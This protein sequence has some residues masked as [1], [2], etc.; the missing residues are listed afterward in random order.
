MALTIESGV[1]FS[2]NAGNSN[3]SITNSFKVS[4]NSNLASQSASNSIVF[5]IL[6]SGLADGTVFAWVNSGIGTSSYPQIFTDGVNNGTVTINNNRATITRT[7]TATAYSF[8]QTTT[9]STYEIQI[10]LLFGYINGPHV[11]WSNAV[12]VTDIISNTP[13]GEALYTSP[14]TYTFTVPAGVSYISMVAVGAGGTSYSTTSSTTA[15]PREYPGSGGGLRYLNDLPVTP[16]ETFTVIVPEIPIDTGSNIYA[17]QSGTFNTEIKRNSNNTQILYAQSGRT[18]SDA[19]GGT[20]TAIG[21][22]V[23]NSLPVGGGDGGR[24]GV[25]DILKFG[26]SQY[27]NYGG[28]YAFFDYGGGGGGAGGYYGPGG[29]GA[30]MKNDYSSDPSTATEAMKIM[31]TDSPPGAGGGG[32]GGYFG[33]GGGGV[34]LYGPGPSGAAGQSFNSI[35]TISSRSSGQQVPYDFCNIDSTGLKTTIFSGGGGSGGDGG[36]IPYFDSSSKNAPF[37][38]YI[39][40]GRT[41]GGGAGAGG[42]TYYITR[43]LLSSGVRST[44]AKGGPA[45]VRIIWGK[46]NITGA[47]SSN[48]TY[49]VIPK[50]IY[51]TQGNI[52]S[53]VITSPGVPDGTVIYWSNIGTTS[54]SDFED[55]I[56][57]GTFTITNSSAILERKLLINNYLEIDET[58][59]IQIRLGSSTGKLLATSITVIVLNT[60]SPIFLTYTSAGE[61]MIQDQYRVL[62]FTQSGTFTVNGDPNASTTVE[63]LCVGGGGASGNPTSGYLNLAG[64]GGAQF[65]TGSF[66]VYTGE[67]YNIT[68]GRGGPGGGAGGLPSSIKKASDNSTIAYSL[69]GGSAAWTTFYPAA[70]PETYTHAPLQGASAA[71]KDFRGS[72]NYRSPLAGNGGGNPVFFNIR[73]YI[74]SYQWGGGGGGGAGSAGADAYNISSGAIGGAGG[75]GLSSDITGSTVWYCGGGGGGG[76]TR[77]GAPGKGGGLTNYG[78]GG[79]G[80][81]NKEYP[82]VTGGPGIVIVRYKYTWFTISAYINTVSKTIIEGRTLIFT[83]STSSDNI[84]QTFYWKNTGTTAASDFLEN[85]NSGSFTCVVDDRI[86]SVGSAYGVFKLTVLPDSVTENAETII[87]QIS[88]TS[89]GPTIATSTTYTV[90]SNIT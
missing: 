71:G 60:V 41:Y 78:G 14:G 68:V 83:F 64:G 79:N 56:N 36:S 66:T 27:L 40:L 45:A 11:A 85:V 69:Q 73:S 21:T 15:K 50:R 70:T 4:V 18:G 88:R 2:T 89:T 13:T 75:D 62:T 29:N 1:S 3:I 22:V 30:G 32:G 44:G 7:L 76:Y 47:V 59:I 48:D 17:V 86:D 72:P 5:D 63:Y 34:G 10:E 84:G 8:L 74:A 43:Y 58:I 26:T 38:D 87:I 39:F 67:T 54:A 55:N 90:A 46:Y 80:G 9:G 51:V 23:Q 61:T 49:S 65:V 57:S 24:S 35:K 53:F 42:V 37:A 12:A 81:P 31:A 25:K 6:T 16:G 77:G 52:A 28:V 20:G 82:V 33:G 19:P